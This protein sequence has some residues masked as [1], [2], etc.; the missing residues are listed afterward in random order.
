MGHGLV[1]IE[2]VSTQEIDVV[3]N[4]RRQAGH[5]LG[6]HFVAIGTQKVQGRIHIGVQRPWREKITVSAQPAVL[7][8]SKYDVDCRGPS[9][10]DRHQVVAR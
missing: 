10:Q 1:Q 6:F 5:V 2:G 9:R 7:M 4:Q 8:V 3:V